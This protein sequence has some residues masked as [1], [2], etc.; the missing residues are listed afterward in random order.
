ME[1]F[2]RAAAM[3]REELIKEIEA[4]CLLFLN[5]SPGTAPGLE[6]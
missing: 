2:E 1:Y 5:C 4:D 3:T 6:D